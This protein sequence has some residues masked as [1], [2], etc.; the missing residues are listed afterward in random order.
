M[1]KGELLA[2]MEPLS[3][4]TPIMFYAKPNLARGIAAA[5]Y[6]L[7]ADGRGLVVLRVLFSPTAKSILR[8]E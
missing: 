1:T 6:R 7:D 5:R 3:D 4:D 8:S 2:F